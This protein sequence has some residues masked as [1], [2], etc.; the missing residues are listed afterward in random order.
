MNVLKNSIALVFLTLLVLSCR[1]D[2]QNFTDDSV[3]NSEEAIAQDSLRSL[4]VGDWE[5]IFYHH[6][7]GIYQDTINDTSYYHQYSDTVWIKEGSMIKDP[8][9]HDKLI[10]NYGL[11]EKDFVISTDGLYVTCHENCENAGYDTLGAFAYWWYLAPPSDTFDSSYTYNLGVYEY[12]GSA[13]SWQF[14]GSHY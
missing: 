12:Y 14:Y 11:N 10:V 6:F 7:D 4:F 2:E 3:H 8:Y 1:K 13:N 5:F 9:S